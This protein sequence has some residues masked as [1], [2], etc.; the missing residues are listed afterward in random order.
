MSIS[1]S[2]YNLEEQTTIATLDGN[3]L[4][5][6]GSGPNNYTKI[7]DAIDDAVAG[8]TVFVYNGTYYENVVV[9]KSISLIGEDRDSTVINGNSNG[10]V[11]YITANYTLIIGFKIQNGNDGIY[12]YNCKYSGIAR[13]IISNNNGT[14]IHICNYS[15]F[16]TIVENEIINNSI[17]VDIPSG[18]GFYNIITHNNFI[19]NLKTV[20]D[21][22]IN[23]W[24]LYYPSCGNYWS[25]YS[26]V[27]NFSGPNQDMS[28]PDGVGDTPY[29][30]HG[31]DNEDRYPLMEPYG[32]TE[33]SLNFIRGGLFKF[34]G[35]L[36][37]IGNHTALNVQWN[38]TVDGG[39]VL[40]GNQSSGTLPKP[41]IAG[42]EETIS[43]GIILGFGPITI[44]IAVWADNAPYVS[45]STP[46]FLLL[47]FI[48]INPGGGI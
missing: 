23:D 40:L 28:S 20:I 27:D 17:G 11:V 33:L 26:G 9:E 2:G 47:F 15:Y 10:R 29:P 4:Y 32:I 1:S 21:E 43:T 39:F 16:N 34:S 38:I 41:L 36:K 13:N 24:N 6:G 8:D 25:D 37:N 42:E 3:T 19:N 7:Q 35:G 46:G 44:T 45:K 18:T 12:L 22:N 5:V 14:G 31:G 48:Q 30:I